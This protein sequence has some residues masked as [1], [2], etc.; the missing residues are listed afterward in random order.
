MSGKKNTRTA[1]V[2]KKATLHVIGQRFEWQEGLANQRAHLLNFIFFCRPRVLVVWENPSW[3]VLSGCVTSK[4]FLKNVF[5]L[6]ILN[7]IIT[8]AVQFR[9]L[10]SFMCAQVRSIFNF[11]RKPWKLHLRYVTA[12]CP[13]RASVISLTQT[14][15]F[16][17]SLDSAN[18]Y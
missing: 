3:R 16:F 10:S 12:S 9:L 18:L 11:G 4:L 13:V 17:R 8:Q 6:Y 15:A 14:V 1:S 7:W 2:K 5:M